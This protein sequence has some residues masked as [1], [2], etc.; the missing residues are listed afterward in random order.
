M[1]ISQFWIQFLELVD[2]IR[3]LRDRVFEARFYSNTLNK[4]S[5]KDM[6]IT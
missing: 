1:D 5:G 4:R 3:I 2:Q 6:R